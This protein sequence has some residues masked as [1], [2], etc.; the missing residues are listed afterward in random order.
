MDSEPE[1]KTLTALEKVQFEHARR[2]RYEK[3]MKLIRK[4]RKKE[5]QNRKR[6]RK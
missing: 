4:K 6:N 1:P 3:N 2:V 5:R